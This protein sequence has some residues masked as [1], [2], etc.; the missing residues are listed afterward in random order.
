MAETPN[1]LEQSHYEVIGELYMTGIIIRKILSSIL[2][3]A[4]GE[5]KSSAKNL[6][7]TGFHDQLSKTESKREM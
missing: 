6:L 1:D 5:L 7:E 3:E 2:N 4:N